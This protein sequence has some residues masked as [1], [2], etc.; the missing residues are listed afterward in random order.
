MIRQFTCFIFDENRSLF[1]KLPYC[2]TNMPII[3]DGVVELVF[4]KSVRYRANGFLPDT[5]KAIGKL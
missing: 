1:N 2:Y 5:Y 3:N 4:N